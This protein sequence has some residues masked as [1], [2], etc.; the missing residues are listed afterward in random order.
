MIS[1]RQF[2]TWTSKIQNLVKQLQLDPRLTDACLKI[3]P[4]EY[5]NGCNQFVYVYIQGTVKAYGW[6][7]GSSRLNMLLSWASVAHL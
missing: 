6:D 2:Y 1:A 7:F 3:N 4:D 5:A